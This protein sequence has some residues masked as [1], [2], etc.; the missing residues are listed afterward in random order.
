[1]DQ[2]NDVGALWENFMMTERLK[3]RTYASQISNMYFWRTYQQQEIDLVEERD[4]NLFGYEFKWS[5]QKN[6]KEPSVW[7]ITYPNSQ[8]QMITSED[9]FSFII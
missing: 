3:Y 9:Y 6:N 1:L 4:G 7:R 2:R 8:Y 5:P